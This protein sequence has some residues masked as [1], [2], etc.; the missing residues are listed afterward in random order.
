MNLTRE[1]AIAILDHCTQFVDW[2]E[3]M[4]DA[5][6]YDEEAEICYTVY[7]VFEKLGIGREEVVNSNLYGD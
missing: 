4:Q 2:C 6:L 3:L 7:E 1:K 5:D